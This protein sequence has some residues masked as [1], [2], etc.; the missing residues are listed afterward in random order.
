MEAPA[1]P[2][3]VIQEPVY[4]LDF[5]VQQQK[6]SWICLKIFATEQYYYGPVPTLKGE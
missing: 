6:S 4:T 5:R 1:K 3:E 2:V